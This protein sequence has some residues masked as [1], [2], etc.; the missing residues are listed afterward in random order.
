MN[1][2]CLRNNMLLKPCFG[3]FY[4]CFVFCTATSSFAI[5]KISSPPFS[6]VIKSSVS[7]CNLRAPYTLP[8]ITWGGD[9]P[10]VYAN[11]GTLQTGKGSI[12]DQNGV[13]VT[14]KREDVFKNQVQAYLE[15][16][17]PF[18]RGTAG[19]INLAADIT[20]KDPRTK[21]KVIYQLTWSAG[22]DA[23][24]VKGNISSPKDLKG[25]TVAVQAYGPHVDYLSKV[26]SDAGLSLADVNIYWTKDLTGTDETPGEAFRKNEV[27][28]AMV[29]I[30]DALALTSGGAV[31]TGAEDSVRGAKILLSTKSA[32]RIIS[33]VYAVR[34]DF[35]EANQVFVQNFVRSLLL[36]ADE[37]SVLFKNNDTNEYRE[38][39]KSAARILL[40]SDQATKDAEDMY[41]DAE[42]AGAKGN[43]EFFATPTYPRKFE[44]LNTEIQNGFRLAGLITST[45]NPGKAN[46][47]FAKLQAGL[48]LQPEESRERFNPQQVARVVSKKQQQGTLDESGLF[49]FEVYFQPNQSEFSESL[50]EQAF[51]KAIDLA[52]TYGG[53]ILTVEGHSDPLGYLKQ[54]KAGETDIILQRVRQSAKNLSL[55]RANMVKDSLVNYAK[56]KGITIDPSQFAVIGH[57]IEK[58]ASGMCGNLP[59][60]PKTEQEWLNNMRVEFR[61]VQVEAES[62]VFKPL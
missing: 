29:I 49:S 16:R 20:E 40:D 15:C 62:S 34:S 38:M 32:N 19:M 54:K 24:V 39:I 14:L 26:L 2:L 28:A 10:T 36:S 5:D 33:D 46:W 47:D 56:K 60:A 12:F 30:P 1:S 44:N 22:G 37:V 4:F 13:Q 55:S 27:H 58:P 42:F 48:S 43:R 51:K 23:M 41:A 31:G 50:Y 11:G 53:A 18:L 25:K 59:C 21:L 52:A 9:I 8:L 45:V 17:T 3:V 57:G 6:K 61:I 7:D 35:Y